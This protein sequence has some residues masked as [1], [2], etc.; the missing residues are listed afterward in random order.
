[1]NGFVGPLLSGLSYTAHLVGGAVLGGAASVIG[2]GKFADG[3]VTG[4]FAYLMSPAPLPS[5]PRPQADSPY[6]AMASGAPAGAVPGT[7]FLNVLG[8]LGSR[9]LGVFGMLLSL[10]G[11]TIQTQYFYHYTSD[12]GRA[13][14]TQ[15]G[16]ISR[17]ADGFVYLTP[18]IYYSGAQAQ[19]YLAL[20]R[21]PTG[22]FQISAADVG[23]AS[24]PTV[25]QPAN[26]QPGGWYEI[27]VPAPD[28]INNAKWVPIGP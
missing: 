2:G 15:D 25:V 11:D 8:T 10:S 12:L 28:P 24:P 6:D 20:S 4:A 17:S 23:P 5:T 16:F 7:G 27:R 22:F 9:I 18:D 21:A 19:Q 13:G 14:I 1:V 3:A 26:G